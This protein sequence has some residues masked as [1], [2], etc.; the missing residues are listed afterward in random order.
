MQ[1]QKR[2]ENQGF[3]DPPKPQKLGFRSRAAS[4]LTFSANHQK[5]TKIEKQ[6]PNVGTFFIKIHQKALPK[7]S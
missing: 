1:P 7:R 3:S 6:T 4:I 5:V 2:S